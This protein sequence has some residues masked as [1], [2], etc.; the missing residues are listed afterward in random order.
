[1]SHSRLLFV[2][3]MIA[4]T[5]LAAAEPYRLWSGSA[6]PKNPADLS[7]PVGMVESIIHRPA[8]DGAKFLHGAAIVHHDGVLYANWAASPTNENGP[9][10]Q[11]HG[12]RSTDGGKT[13]SKLETVAPGFD[14]PDR[15]SHGVL[16][17]HNDELWTI[18]ARFGVGPKAR[19][20]PGLKAEAFVLD[21]KTNRWNSRGIVADNCWPY[22]QPVRMSNGR[23]ITGGQDKNGLPV[24]MI[25]QGDDLTKKWDTILIPY[26]PALKPSFAETT[27]WAEGT[28]VIAVIR[29]GGGVAWVATS[30]D[31]G[32]TWSKARRSNLHMPRAKAYLG[33]LSTGQ[34]YL[35]HNV[36]NRDTLAISVSAPGQSTLSRAWKIRHGK[37]DAPRYPGH[38]KAPQWSYPYGYEHDGKLYV[39]YSVGKEECGLSVIP[40]ASLAIDEPL[41]SVGAYVER[42]MQ[43]FVDNNIAGSIRDFDKAVQLNPGIEP[44]LWQRGISY[45]YAGEFT[46]G[47]KQFE[48]HRT[49][50]PHDVENATWHFICVAKT[51]GIDAARKKL[52]EIDTKRDRRVPLKEVYEYYAGRAKADD[53]LVA[54]KDAGPR[55]QMYAHLYLGLYAEA[56]GDAE[57]AKKHMRASAAV[58]MGE[59]YM[60]D[61]AKVHVKQRGW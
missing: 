50:N 52:I 56:T 23:F 48:I 43:R 9:H 6:L 46:K 42:G 39:V 40:I 55:A 27:V 12:R 33:K 10:E 15:H 16:F 18:C 53:V 34:L 14:G 20:F 8:A 5:P 49:V 4:A 30:D 11:M 26:D 19:R 7:K 41:E 36:R 45:Y 1:M 35:V 57:A 25:S 38:A 17:E 24:V 37:S 28:H 32:R 47:V 60:Q 22:D 21:K 59:H 3:L 2:L 58:E 61:V 31:F 51:E 54:A 44:R 13:W 29:G